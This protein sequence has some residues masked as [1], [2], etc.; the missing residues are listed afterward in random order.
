MRPQDGE[1]NSIY[2][3]KLSEIFDQ[4]YPARIWCRHRDDIYSEL[5]SRQD[6]DSKAESPSD[7]PGPIP[8]LIPIRYGILTSAPPAEYD[9]EGDRECEF[10][11]LERYILSQAA[12]LGR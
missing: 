8:I 3:T 10:L 7:Q 11:H 5:K 6:S 4:V 2:D 1:R 9:N 12:C